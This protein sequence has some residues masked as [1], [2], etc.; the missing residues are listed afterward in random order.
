MTIPQTF[1]ICGQTFK[2]TIKKEPVRINGSNAMGFACHGS[3]AIYLCKNA[4]L[5]DYD[6]SQKI[7]PL[8]HEEMINTFWHEFW[9]VLVNHTG[10]DDIDRERNAIVFALVASKFADKNGDDI[11]GM[12]QDVLK[13]ARDILPEILDTDWLVLN[14]ALSNTSF[15]I[16]NNEDTLPDF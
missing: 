7:F 14:Y 16:P 2:V 1:T 3:S 9:H 11:F 4:M 6:N 12:L 15:N 5:T 8:S 13:E 10:L